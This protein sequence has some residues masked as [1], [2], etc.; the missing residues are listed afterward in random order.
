MSG[1]ARDEALVAVVAA[2]HAAVYAYGVIGARVPI[3]RRAEASGAFAAH[4]ARRDTT[5]RM[6]RD[7]GVE[8]PRA[9]PA[10]QVGSVASAAAVTALAVRVEEAVATAWAAFLDATEDPADRRTGVTAMGECAVRAASWRGRPVPFP[11]RP[12]PGA[13]ASPSGSAAGSAAPSTTPTR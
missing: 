7:A 4:R 12:Q 3:A 1:D 9:E 10:Y 2:E 11:G 8:P 13:S 6:L 5:T